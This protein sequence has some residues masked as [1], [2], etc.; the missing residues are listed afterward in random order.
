MRD[1]GI[2]L[3]AVAVCILIAGLTVAVIIRFNLMQLRVL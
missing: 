2:I 3:R 1:K